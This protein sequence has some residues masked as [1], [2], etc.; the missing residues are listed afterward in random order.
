MRPKSVSTSGSISG[1]KTEPEGLNT[2]TNG[3][4]TISRCYLVLR[5]PDDGQS[6]ETQ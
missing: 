4:S 6:P 5:I 2:W 1:V 3:E